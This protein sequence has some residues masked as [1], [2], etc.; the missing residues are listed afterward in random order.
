MKFGSEQELTSYKK[1]II[2]LLVK[3]AQSDDDFSIVE[4]KYLKYAGSQ[5]N[6]SDK[7]LAAI[8]LNPDAFIIAPPHDEAKRVTILYYLLFM[9]RADQKI[10]AEEE[11]LCFKIG[12]RLG[13]REEMVRNLIDVMKEYL[14]QQIPPESMLNKIK[15]YL[16]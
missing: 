2:S 5:M 7:D 11:R 3:Q 6:L 8:R 12:L 4:K 14:H 10:T 16:N 9:M 15:P 13:F 1:Y